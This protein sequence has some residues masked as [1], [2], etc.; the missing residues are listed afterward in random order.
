MIKVIF[1]QEDAQIKIAVEGDRAA[2]QIFSQS[3]IGQASFEIVS[4]ELPK[5]LVM[6]F[7]LRGLE[8]LR[9]AYDET[10]VTTSLSSTGENDIR[11][12]ISR[13]AGQPL[14]AQIIMPDS[15]YWMKM[16]VVSSD[17]FRPQIPLQNGYI[18]VEAP[19][20]F[21]KGRHR[22]ASLQWVDFFR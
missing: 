2:I 20:D 15:P 22:Q 16:R 14:S 13:A 21:L 4:E 19:E 5:K 9:F 6:R 3:G 17:N 10:I 1:H 8:E 12:S 7:Y 11:Q 18:E